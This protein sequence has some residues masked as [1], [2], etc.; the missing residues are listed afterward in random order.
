MAASVTQE[1]D[2]VS[3]LED[4]QCKVGSQEPALAL[5]TLNTEQ[6]QQLMALLSKS[7][8]EDNNS[9]SSIGTGFLA[10]KCFCFLTSFA[11]RDW[12]IDSGASDHITPDLGILTFVQKLSIPGFITMPNGKHSRIEHIG[13]V[14]LSPTLLL[15]DVLHVPDFQ[16]NLLSVHKLCK[17][18]AGKVI[19]TPTDCTLQ[20]PI[21]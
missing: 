8:S 1:Q 10:G 3:W 2:G 11:N 7:Q 16:F 20:S 18:V 5:P 6:Y 13:S 12:I 19:F 14:Q 9:G 15:T 21:Q 17:Q 4:T